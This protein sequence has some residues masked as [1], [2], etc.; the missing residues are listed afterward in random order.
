[1]FIPRAAAAR[2]VFTVIAIPLLLLGAASAQTPMASPEAS[3]VAIGTGCA[4][5]SGWFQDLA[6][7]I[8]G[9]QG[10]ALMQ[11][12]DFDALALTEDDA[13]LVVTS[14]NTLIP[15]VEALTPPAPAAAYHRAY[16]GM[17]GW[18]RDLAENRDSAAHQRLIN[19]DRTLFAQMGQAVYL[20][21]ATCGTTTWN[22]A[23][24]AAFP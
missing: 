6:A 10:L 8:A 19:N 24:S 3:P 5:L 9:N 7:M 17:L 23:W 4:E 14:L 16:L 15:E 18:Y 12:V 21:Q 20:G 22:D 11:S 2:H 13:T 1:M